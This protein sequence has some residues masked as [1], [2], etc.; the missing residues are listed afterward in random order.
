MPR[1]IR[2]FP[3]V[4]VL[5]FSVLFVYCLACTDSASS[6]DLA[7]V[8]GWK[9]SQDLRVGSVDDPDYSL[10]WFRTLEVGPDGRMYTVHPQEQLIR[11]FSEDGTLV[12]TI[13]GRGE[14]PGEFQNVGPIGWVGDSLWVLDFNGYKFNFFNGDGE[15]LSSFSVPFRFGEDP[16][17]PQPPRASGLLA[18]GS[19]YGAPPAFSDQIEEGTITHHQLLLMSSEGEVIDSI[20]RVPFGRNQWAI[21]DPDNPRKGMLF[22]RQPYGDGPLW[23]FF[24][25]ETS[26]AILRREAPTSVEEAAF[27][28]EKISV[29]GDTIFAREYRYAPVP[30]ESAEADSVLDFN[31][32]RWADAG[33]M[34]GVARGRL[35]EWARR[36]LYTPSFKT[37][38]F[39]MVLAKGGGFWLQG[40]SEP[41]GLNTWYYLD[42]MGTPLGR[43]ELP[44][45]FQVFKAT[46]ATLWGSERDDL[47]VSYL[48]R[49]KVDG[50]G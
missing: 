31:V 15:F 2:Q 33:I 6:N 42:P 49:Y 34:G 11:M 18:D 21:Y 39:Q 12:G 46:A 9:A 40:E 50:G 7:A 23:G 35:E 29:S 1:A 5:T 45:N 48:V 22:T 43:I 30:L 36:T 17:S 41:S 38:I 27:H 32:N 26:Y 37:P 16:D 47:D 44:A 10:T 28:L 8:Q 24:D 4:L 3:F 13:G 19:I 25:D 14:G 20:F